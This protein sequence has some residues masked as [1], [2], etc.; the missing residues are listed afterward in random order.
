[1]AF[2]S[3]D[4]RDDQGSTL[5]RARAADAASEGDAKAAQGPLIGSDH[6]LVGAGWVDHK[7]AGPEVGL[8][9]RGQ[10]GG[11]RRHAGGAI[12][13]A[14]EHSGDLQRQFVIALDLG[15]GQDHGVEGFSHGSL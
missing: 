1:M 3:L 8:E 4:V 2:E 11:E 9:T 13:L 15:G 10:H 12:G 14:F 7:E 6:Q 5:R